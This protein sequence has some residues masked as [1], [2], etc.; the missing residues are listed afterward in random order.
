MAQ[1][2]PDTGHPKQDQQRGQ[3]KTLKHH[4]LWRQ[5][6]GML[7]S[8]AFSSHKWVRHQKQPQASLILHQR[9]ECSLA[10]LYSHPQEDMAVAG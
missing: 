10:V 7:L 6:A 2:Y 5:A 4:T 9:W 3:C 8:T 1:T